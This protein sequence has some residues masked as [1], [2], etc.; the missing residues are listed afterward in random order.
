LVSLKTSHDFNSKARKQK[1][2]KVGSTPVSPHHL[3]AS[4]KR[5]HG[6]GLHPTMQPPTN[7]TCRIPRKHEMERT[8]KM[9]QNN[10]IHISIYYVFVV[11]PN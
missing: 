8:K 9:I 6:Q 3:V 11:P 4:N 7:M 2:S 5:V 10:T 1:Y